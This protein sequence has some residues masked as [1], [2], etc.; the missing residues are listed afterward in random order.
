[1]DRRLSL[2]AFFRRKGQCSF[3]VWAPD[4]AT[5]DLRILSPRSRLVRLQRGARGYHYGVLDG[6]EPGALYLYRLDGLIERPDPASR[7]QPHGPRGPSCLIDPRP[8]WKDRQWR[9]I[10]LPD[11]MIHEGSDRTVA[12]DDVIP[13]LRQLRDLG[14]TALSVK[15][16]A[17]P[18]AGPTALP[19]SVPA[20]LGG[21]A[22]LMRLVDTCHRQGLAVMLRT[23]LFEPGIEG[24]PFAS[25][26]PYF[27]GPDRHINIDGPHSDEVRRYF[28]ESVLRWFREFHIDALDV[29]NI[30][31]LTDLS[32]TPLLEEMARAV[33]CE[34]E[35][36]ARPLHLIARS[37]RN[38]PRLIRR[39]EDGGIGLD[40][41]WNPDFSG[42]LQALVAGQRKNHGD[43][44]GG[45]E[46]IKKAFLEGF[47]CSGDYSFP[48][49]CRHGRSSR[50]LPGERFLVCCP[51]PAI[52]ERG[53]KSALESQKLVEATLLL[54]PFVPLI[55]HGPA[56]SSHAASALAS[57]FG[58]LTQLRKELRVM[59][60]LDKQSMGALGYEKE[61]ILLARYW[62]DEGE[63]L[64]L[65]NFGAKRASISIPFPDGAWVLRFDSSD[66]RWNGR[67]SS[68][69]VLVR[70]A[71]A[72]IPLELAARSCAV[73]LRQ[74]GA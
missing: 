65:F 68:L 3:L 32:P 9:G 2:G 19:C 24:D 22:G 8:A 43:D 31:A 33:R 4:V 60:L 46:Q 26:G 50:T 11:Y 49:L 59:G 55:S 54:S 63:I 58:E 52:A 38:D 35:I 20:S 37:D 18:P 36:I 61:K 6:I 29:G 69:S 12:F 71:G 51:R 62:K 64:V 66:R 57:Y 41:L 30:D 45:I 70:G 23:P 14:V 1:M 67:G 56:E 16:D 44:F 17:P 39:W 72:E 47:V 27:T 74:R 13:G 34:A 48:R 40:A 28:V 10:P 53:S 21:P 73:Y 25:F 5:V 42:A 15:L 7:Y